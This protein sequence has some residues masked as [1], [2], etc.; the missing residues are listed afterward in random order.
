MRKWELLVVINIFIVSN[1]SHTQFSQFMD[2]LFINFKE[3]N[4][5]LTLCATTGLRSLTY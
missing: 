4:D 5:C 1:I 2:N 3:I